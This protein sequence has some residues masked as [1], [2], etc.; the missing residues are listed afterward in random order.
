MPI[1]GAKNTA[2]NSRTPRQ[3]SKAK[4]TSG[5]GIGNVDPEEA[6]KEKA[7]IRR[8]QVRKAQIQHRQRKANYIKQLEQDIV[9]IREMITEAERQSKQLKNE[10]AFMRKKLTLATTNL[11]GGAIMYPGQK[12]QS[13]S[14]TGVDFTSGR[15]LSDSPVFSPDMQLPPAASTTSF[16]SDPSLD[17]VSV[18]LRMDDAMNY[19]CLQ[20]ARNSSPGAS[21]PGDASSAPSP[22]KAETGSPSAQTLT[23]IPG[24]DL[25]PEQTDQAINFILA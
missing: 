23:G 2:P 13:L 21:G 20:F 22:P 25:T 4:G 15:S 17:N 5:S 8:A 16:F 18:S 10:N 1:I 14:P 6:A 12:Q 24:I 19:P 11:A 7:Q 9:Q 3:D